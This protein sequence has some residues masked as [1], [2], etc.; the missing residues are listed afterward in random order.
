[1]YR[2]LSFES[3][4]IDETEQ[5][6]TDSFGKV[7]MGWPTFSRI[8]Q[9]GVQD[10]RFTLS[11]LAFAG[12]Y[13]SLAD[14]DE[15]NIAAASSSCPW[16]EG[17][18]SGDFGTSPKLFRPGHPTSVVV[19]DAAVRNVVLG[20]RTLERTA[21]LLYGQDDLVVAFDGGETVG[22][23]AGR[24]WL[25]VV[26][27]AH[28]YA[29]AGALGNELVRSSLYRLLAVTALESFRLHAD[30]HALRL[31][32]ERRAAI[33]RKAA[34]FFREYASLPVTIEDAAEAAGASVPELVLAFRAHEL[35]GATPTAYLRDVRL[36]AALDDLRAGDPTLGDTVREIAVRWGFGSASRFAQ[37]FRAKY[38][39]NPK[40]VLDR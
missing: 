9:W 31:S 32:A 18:D 39:I 15:F 30:R 22:P 3:T 23:E 17:R 2:R 25:R 29:R 34:E 1:M 20:R 19:G 40:W 10:D 38:G 13:T 16:E 35:D 6:F 33:H 28:Q 8:E 11:F 27:V 36:A 14:T 21:R 24:A 5:F 26:E 7:E 12:G 4:D 37:L